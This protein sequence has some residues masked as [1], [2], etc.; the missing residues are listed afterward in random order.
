MINLIKKLLTNKSFHETIRYTIGCL[1]G[2]LIKLVVTL[3]TTRLG[4]GLDIGYLVATFTLLFFSFWFHYRITFKQRITGIKE[5]V[6]PFGVYVISVV[7]FKLAD[8]LIVVLGA[9]ALKN[10]LQNNI[11]ITLFWQQIINS[12]CIVCASGLLFTLRFFVYKVIFKKVTPELLNYYTGKVE[13]VW[14]GHATNNDISSNAASGGIVS[15]VLANLL[16]SGQID[17]ALVSKMKIK[18][19]MAMPHGVI[20]TNIDELVAN[21]GSI[22]IDFPLLNKETIEKIKAFNGS[23]AVVALPC[24][25]NALRK[26][27][28]NDEQLNDKI[29]LIIGLY[30]GHTSQPELLDK[31]FEKKGIK[32]QDVSSFRFRKGLWRG[33]AQVTLKNGDTISW[34]TA[35]YNL[36]QNLFILSAKRCL[37]CTDHYAEQADISCG[38]IWLFKHRKDSVKHSI[39][40]ARTLQ[41]IQ[42]IESCIKAEDISVTDSTQEELF[43][44]N[45]RAAI[46]HKAI[47]ARAKACSKYSQNIIVPAEAQK[48]R[49]NELLAAKLIAKIQ[50]TPADKMMSKNRRYLKFLLYVFKGLT[51]F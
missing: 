18:D 46:Y 11:D 17:G 21:Q 33:T 32:Y 41:G 29:K 4:V 19:G 37:Y 51:N 26:M 50:H 36:Y 7:W 44:A 15:S 6:K 42:A 35:F 20:A 1:C 31:V 14:V 25:V 12:G 9:V 2:L 8:Y 24:Q 16:T 45:K 30:C 27:M 43:K 28:T 3:I 48:A 49:W 13:K 34:P 5:L 23:L 47:A 22:Y 10:Y 38:D 39:F 40:T